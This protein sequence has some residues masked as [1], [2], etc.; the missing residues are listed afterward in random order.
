LGRRLRWRRRR[1]GSRPRRRAS[2]QQAQLGQNATTLGDRGGLASHSDGGDGE[3]AERERERERNERARV[4]N[5]LPLARLSVSLSVRHQWRAPRTVRPCPRCSRRAY[6][7]EEGRS[8]WVTRSLSLACVRVFFWRRKRRKQECASVLSPSLP[9][10][11][12]FRASPCP[13]H[14]HRGHRTHTHTQAPSAPWAATPR[15]RAPWARRR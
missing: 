8:E 5:R 4:N 1:G 15:T 3:G 11:F 12:S 13:A 7:E 10:H 2:A 6:R 14:T 9:P